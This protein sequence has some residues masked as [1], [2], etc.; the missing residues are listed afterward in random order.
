MASVYVD[1]C[2]K[3]GVKPVNEVQQ[4]LSRK[5]QEIKISSRVVV[6]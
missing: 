3:K 5:E 1:A 6:V 4:A 2:V